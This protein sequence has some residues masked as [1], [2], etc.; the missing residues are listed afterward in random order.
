MKSSKFAGSSK[1]STTGR[2][3][4]RGGFGSIGS[5]MSGG[6]VGG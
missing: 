5:H 1:S 4:S 2:S 3:I 6:H